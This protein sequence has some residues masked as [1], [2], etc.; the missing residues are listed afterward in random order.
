MYHTNVTNPNPNPDTNPINTYRTSLELV[1]LGLVMRFDQSVEYVVKW[2]API[3]HHSSSVTYHPSLILHLA[4]RTVTFL[5][6]SQ[7][8]GGGAGCQH[9]HSGVRHRGHQRRRGRDRCK[10]T[11]RC[12]VE[13]RLK[14]P[15]LTNQKMSRKIHDF[16]VNRRNVALRQFTNIMNRVFFWPRVVIFCCES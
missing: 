7:R 1:P 15:F 3:L 9:G 5:M 10:S 13:N 8:H 16:F 12:A 4:Y 11:N 6:L 2:T 14:G